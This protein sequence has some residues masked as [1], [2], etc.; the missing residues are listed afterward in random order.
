MP[1]VPYVEEERQSLEKLNSS[2]N[3][4]RSD[5]RKSAGQGETLH[6]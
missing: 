1:L 4:S 6:R 2:S 5:S 3:A